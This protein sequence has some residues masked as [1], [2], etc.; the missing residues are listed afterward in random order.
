MANTVTNK[1]EMSSSIT[2]KIK[3]HLDNMMEIVDQRTTEQ[4]T[5]GERTVSSNN[6][7]VLSVAI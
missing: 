3:N 7:L 2:N 6:V 4:R 1:T 5:A